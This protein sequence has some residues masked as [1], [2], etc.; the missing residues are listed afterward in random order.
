MSKAWV[1]AQE[2]FLI[3]ESS[4]VSYR[5]PSLERWRKEIVKKLMNVAWDMWR[6][7]NGVK[8]S[9]STPAKRRLVQEMDLRI[10]TEFHLGTSTLLPQHR[11]WLA[12][13]VNEVLQYDPISKQQWLASVDQCRLAHARHQPVEDAA[14]AAQRSFMERWLTRIPRDEPEN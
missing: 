8:H 14:I 13:D 9:A 3:R 7:R 10:R 5:L 6:H 12:G 1:A 4:C 11:Y 2:A